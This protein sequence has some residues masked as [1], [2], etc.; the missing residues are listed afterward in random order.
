[1]A[2]RKQ[3]QSNLQVDPEFQRVMQNARCRKVTEEE[4]RAQRISFAY[5][6]ALN[7]EEITKDTV[8][9]ASRSIRLAGTAQ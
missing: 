1:M 5:G 3:F 8:S 9:D 7:A 6:N 2:A 4:L